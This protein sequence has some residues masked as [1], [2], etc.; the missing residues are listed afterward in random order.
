MDRRVTL[1]EVAVYGAMLWLIGWMARD[2]YFFIREG[3]AVIKTVFY[4]LSILGLAFIWV[5]FFIKYS[6]LGRYL[7]KAIAWFRQRRAK[8]RETR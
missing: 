8:R 5:S 6:N 4:G 7:R 1:F 3:E 2:V